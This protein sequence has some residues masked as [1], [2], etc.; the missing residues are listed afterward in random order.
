MIDSSMFQFH[1]LKFLKKISKHDKPWSAWDTQLEIPTQIFTSGHVDCNFYFVELMSIKF[2]FHAKKLIYVASMDIS[3]LIRNY[4]FAS[5]LSKTTMDIRAERV[6]EWGLRVRLMILTGFMQEF[7]EKFTCHV[8]ER[9]NFKSLVL[10][11]TFLENLEDF[12]RWT[13]KFTS[14]L[15]FSGQVTPHT[16]S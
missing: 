5:I 7:L 15:Y 12:T 10:C 6:H 11:R 13:K 2:V 8:Y 14:N 16:K 1:N 4:W 3:G 9:Q